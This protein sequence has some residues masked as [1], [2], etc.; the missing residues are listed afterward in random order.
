MGNYSKLI[1]ALIG[2]LMAWAVTAF[3]LPAEWAGEN[4]EMVVGISG[5]VTAVLVY[6][7]PANKEA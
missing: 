4:S 1:A 3:G 2:G 5:V 7:F 6:L